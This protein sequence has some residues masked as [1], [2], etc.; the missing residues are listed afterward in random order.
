MKRFGPMLRTIMV[1]AT[2]MY[3]LSPSVSA[4]TYGNDGERKFNSQQTDSVSFVLDSTLVETGITQ[5][6]MESPM[7][8][9]SHMVEATPSLS[10]RLWD[11][12]AEH[13]VITPLLILG[14]ITA[15]YWLI[16]KI[17]KLTI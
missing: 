11:L 5:A 2:V 9:D 12:V 6:E 13:Y 10:Q 17:H 1:V 16:S 8:S 14:V 4:Q 3:A 7:M 15:I